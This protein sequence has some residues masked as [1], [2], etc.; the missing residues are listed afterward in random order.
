MKREVSASEWA[1]TMNATAFLDAY[2]PDKQKREASVPH[3]SPGKPAPVRSA[4][5]TAPKRK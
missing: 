3:L 1:D 4:P 5:R 2:E